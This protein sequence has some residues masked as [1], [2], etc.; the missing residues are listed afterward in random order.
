MTFKV[1]QKVKYNNEKGIVKRISDVNKNMVFVV[2][3]C[4]EN[5]KMFQNYTAAGVSRKKLTA[6]W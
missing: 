6:G 5:W 2:F 1:G 3:H 4:N